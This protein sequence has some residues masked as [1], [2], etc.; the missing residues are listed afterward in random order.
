MQ[1]ENNFNIKL[2]FT[3]VTGKE[4]ISG[5]LQ[6]TLH[7]ITHNL[8]RSSCISLNEVPFLSTLT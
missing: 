1:D 3:D 6:I 4:R 2:S 8:R 7:K 5:L